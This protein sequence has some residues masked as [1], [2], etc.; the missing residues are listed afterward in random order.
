MKNMKLSLKLIGGFV[1]VAFITLAIGF[2]GWNGAN[3][4]KEDLDTLSEVEIPS[5]NNLRIIDRQLAALRTAQRT[6]LNTNLQLEDRKR[7]Y[8]NVAKAREEYAKAITVVDSLPR[9][10]EQDRL[11]QEFKTELDAW[12][13]KNN[14]FFQTVQELE[15]T[16]IFDPVALEKSLEKFRGDH[17]NLLSK[18]INL[19]HSGENFTGGDDAAQCN[20]GKWIAQFKTTNPVLNTSLSEIVAPHE[21]FHH[22]VEK[23]KKLVNTHNISL[24]E[25][26]VVV[27]DI[28]EKE[29]VPAQ[30]EFM[31]YFAAMQEEASKAKALYSKIYDLAMIAAAQEKKAIAPLARSIHESS[32]EV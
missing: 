18:T 30:E 32:E 24:A 4:L 2:V 10:P 11:W 16:D 12:K 1:I 9:S 13:E 27:S 20:F 31:K 8:E 28:Y 17:Y 3:S 6:L 29:M 23:I 14:E 15:K 25:N 19:I 26:T 5:I 22:A 7:Q 21:K